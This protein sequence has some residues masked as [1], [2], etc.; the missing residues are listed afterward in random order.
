MSNQA[1][2]RKHGLVK[3]KSRQPKSPMYK[4]RNK[5]KARQR[6]LER[7]KARQAIL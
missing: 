7:Q 3:I 2:S 1:N 5:E 6:R 4:R